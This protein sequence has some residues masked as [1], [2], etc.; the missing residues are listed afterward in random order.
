M[1]QEAS[2]EAARLKRPTGPTTMPPVNSLR[3]PTQ[4]QSEGRAAPQVL[5]HRISPSIG[6]R[7]K[8]SNCLHRKLAV[9][10]KSTA[11]DLD[12]VV[13]ADRSL[14]C[15][16]SIFNGSNKCVSS[17]AIHLMKTEVVPITKEQ[18]KRCN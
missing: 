1:S 3:V 2:V 6:G 7:Q 12:L 18:E 17:L 10:Q 8:D 9:S 15:L 4:R 13:G 14:K 11:L 5:S 16:S